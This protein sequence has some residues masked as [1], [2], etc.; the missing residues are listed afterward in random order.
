MEKYVYIN[1][2][3]YQDTSQAEKTARWMLS[4]LDYAIT[5]NPLIAGL[6]LSIGGDGTFLDTAKNARNADIIGINKGTLGFLTEVQESGIAEALAAYGENE[7]YIEPRMM[8]S[9]TALTS[10]EKYVVTGTALND[11]VITKNNQSIIG[12]EIIV[13][14]S[15]VTSYFADGII[16]ST[17]TGSTGYAF[18][19][20]SPII[21]P[22]SEMIIITPIA[23]H[24]ILNRSICVSAESQVEIKIDHARGDKNCRL[25]I[26]GDRNIIDAGGV[27]TIT[28][29]PHYIKYVKFRSSPSFFDNIMEKIS[30]GR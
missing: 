3:P 29:A 17:P 19:C 27:V 13:D 8:I 24:S 1:K 14:G 7:Y 15:R 16:V 2:N 5:P 10:D 21:D 20:G 25:D 11:V 6:A 22:K 30:T 9:C 26:D 18:S 4:R 23:P 12:L 28:K